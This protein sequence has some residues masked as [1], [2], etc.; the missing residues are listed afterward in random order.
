MKQHLICT[1][2]ICLAIAN[3]ASFAQDAQAAAI[4]QRMEE[5][6]GRLNL[7][8]AQV[9]A[10]APVLERTM[11]SQ[12]S[13]LSK[14]GV[15]LESGRDVMQQLGPRNAMAMKKELDAVRADMLD[16]VDDI[17][18]DDQFEEFQRIQNERQAEMR[19]RM[20]GGR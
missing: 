12:Q 11:A 19:K 7:S 15:D 6:R 18:A 16:A 8:D 1:A 13:I 17:L 2:I 10:L 9:E 3:S 4:D 14:Y 20:R 5:A